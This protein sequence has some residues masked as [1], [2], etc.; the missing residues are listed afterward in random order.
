MNVMEA[1]DDEVDVSD[2]DDD[3][4]DGESGEDEDEASSEFSASIF[5]EEEIAE[6]ADRLVLCCLHFIHNYFIGS[7]EDTE[8]DEGEIPDSASSDDQD[9]SVE[10]SDIL[11]DDYERYN[12]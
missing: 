5:D 10:N 12:F 1:E 8:D 3:G 2:G 6:V 9:R 11:V 7:E 4:G